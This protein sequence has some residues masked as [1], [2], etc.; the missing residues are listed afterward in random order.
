MTKTRKTFLPGIT[1]AETQES[2]E[3]Q[4]RSRT[5]VDEK[6]SF[7]FASPA[8]K[9]RWRAMG[10][11]PLET[12]SGISTSPV[13]SNYAMTFRY[14]PGTG[15]TMAEVVRLPTS[16]ARLGATL[17]RMWNS[18]PAS[19][20]T[21]TRPDKAGAVGL[22]DA[23]FNDYLFAWAS[24]LLSGPATPG[25][26]AAVYQLLAGQPRIT[27][28]DSVTDP[29]GRTGVAIADGQGYGGRDYMIIDPQNAELL[30]YT[31]SPVHANRT[32]SSALG[33]VEVYEA[34]G[35]TNRLGIP[36]RS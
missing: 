15:L 20:G 17:R 31:T 21:D 27:I 35:W 25:T 34:T 26:K 28:I 4:N 6:V 22:P 5:I 18:I 24:A 12:A 33:G 14:G 13:T 3:G 30:A 32:I 29:L 1:F 19:G 9:A 2:W 8:V 7:S 11:P 10:K 16:A 36:P 23:T